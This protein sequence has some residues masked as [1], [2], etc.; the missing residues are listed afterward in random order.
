M[1]HAFVLLERSQL[2]ALI[3]EQGFQQSTMADPEQSATLGRLSG[4][5]VMLVGSYSVLADHVHL[6][7][8][9]VDVISG[10]ELSI[11][12]SEMPKTAA[13]YTLLGEKTKAQTQGELA[14]QVLD[15]L[16]GQMKQ[17]PTQTPAKPPAQQNG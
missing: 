17:H 16:L 12:E 15:L 10:E 1:N 13:I 5:E 7:L 14:G 4:A 9:L 2:A 11:G 3:K 6:N 8:R